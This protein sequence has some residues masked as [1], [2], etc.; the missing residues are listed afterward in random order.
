LRAP[1][2]ALALRITGGPGAGLS[3]LRSVERIGATLGLAVSAFLLGDIGAESSIRALGIVV[4]SGVALY[5]IVEIA[6]WSRSA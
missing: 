1:L 5:A 4:L 2:Y 6:L 3:A